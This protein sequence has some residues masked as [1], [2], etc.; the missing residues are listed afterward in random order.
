MNVDYS[1]GNDEPAP[2]P[3]AHTLPQPASDDDDD[4]DF[5]ARDAFGIGRIQASEA[6]E[7][8]GTVVKVDAARASAPDVLVN[9]S[10]LTAFGWLRARVWGLGSRTGV[11]LYGIATGGAEKRKK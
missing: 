2:A 7:K 4:A 8:A 1:S 9:V 3:A 6:P 10:P 5:D 11:R